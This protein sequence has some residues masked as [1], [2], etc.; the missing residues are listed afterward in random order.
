MFGYR[1]SR[2]EID[3]DSA[4][5]IAPTS[6]DNP[7]ETQASFEERL[8]AALNRNRGPIDWTSAKVRND[9]P[10]RPEF[11]DAPYGE[12][13]SP[14]NGIWPALAKSET[15]KFMKLYFSHFHHRWPVLHAPTFEEETAPPVL[16]SCVAMIGAFIH[17][18]NES[19]ELAIDL[20]N[21]VFDHII[22][23]LVCPA[24]LNFQS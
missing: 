19:M 23:R 2:E 11:C 7:V 16:L 9:L 6:G 21:R 20:Q 24:P 18:T 13:Q 5:A 4:E 3:D 1:V 15:S 12:N 14:S 22:P 17:A 10:P 8:A